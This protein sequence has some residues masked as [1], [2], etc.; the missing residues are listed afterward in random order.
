MVDSIDHTEV[1]PSNIVKLTLESLLAED[2]QQ[3]EDY[4]EQRQAQKHEEV[5][6]KYLAHIKVGRH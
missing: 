6:E 1:S 5:K 2:Q 3:F 4:I